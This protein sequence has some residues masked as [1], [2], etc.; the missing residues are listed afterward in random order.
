MKHIFIRHSRL[1]DMQGICYGALDVQVPE[2]II[3]QDATALKK[4]LP[5][6]PIVSSPLQRCAALANA[7][8]VNAEQDVRLLEMN[9]GAWQ[10][11][12]WNDIDR[13]LLDRWAN[14]VTQFRAPNGENFMDVIDRVSE[15]LHDVSKPH[16]VVTHAGVIRAAHFLLGGLEVEDAASLEVPHL[17]PIPL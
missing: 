8:T 4:I 5:A 3:L 2:Q 11:K 15:F 7:L 10:G 9:F 13:V 6:L 1:E 17:R 16:I 14:K 12:A